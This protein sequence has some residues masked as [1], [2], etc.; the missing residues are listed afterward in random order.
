MTFKLQ[1]DWTVI[2]EIE[3]F[4]KSDDI[5]FESGSLV[6][7]KKRVDLKVYMTLAIFLLF[8]FKLHTKISFLWTRDN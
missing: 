4:S 6:V 3:L 7:Q 8:Y 1:Q 2:S 5:S